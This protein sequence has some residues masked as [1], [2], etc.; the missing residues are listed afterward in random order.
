MQINVKVEVPDHVLRP[1]IPVAEGLRIAA[2]H[3]ETQTPVVSRTL[4]D[5]YG[6]QSVSWSVGEPEEPE[7]PPVEPEPE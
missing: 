1:G 5:R 3:I 7:P 2:S 6:N 4:F